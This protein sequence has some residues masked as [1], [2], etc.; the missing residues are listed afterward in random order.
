MT[1][2]ATAQI[3]FD[4]LSLEGA[5]LPPEWL[6]KVAALEAAAQTP[7]DYGIP[8]G[9]QLR[10]EIGRYWRIAQAVW[11][12]FASARDGNDPLGASQRLTRDLLTQ[13]FGF[14]DLAPVGDRVVSG[15]AFPA[16][17]EA[18]G[19]RAPVVFG[20]PTE[21]L[22]QNVP[23]HGDGTRRR[24]AWGVLQ[25]YLNAADGALWGLT[26]NG[27]SLRLGR[28]NASLTRPAWLEADLERIFTEERFADFSVLWLLVHASRFG[29]ADQ[30]VQEAPLERWREAGREQGSRAREVLRVGVE[31]ALRTLGQG[32]VAH[33][34]NGDLRAALASGGLTPGEYFNELLRL[35]YRVIFLLTV[36]ERGILHVPDADA[37]A[38]LLYRDGYGLRRLRER[39]VRHSAHD[40]HGDLWASLGP[41]FSGLG[42]PEGEPALGLPGLGGL[43]GVDQCPHLDAA[44]LENRALLTAVFRLS[45]LREGAALA[46]VNWKDMGV[47]EFGSVYESLLELVPSVSDGGRSF[48]L[49]GG[50]AGN[51]RKT[52][53]SYYTPDSLVQQ[54][55]DTALEPVVAQRLAEHSVVSD[56]ERALLSLAVVDPACGS[57]HF[58]LAAA[59][60]LA[61]HLARLRA[62][63]T[64]GAAEY[65]HALRDVVTHCIHGVDRNPMAL[66]L[67]RMALWLEAFTPDR[68]L[69]FLDHHLVCGDALLGLLDLGV[70]K[71]GIPDEAFKALTGDDKDVAKTLA[72]LNRAGRKELEK[73]NKSGQ[74]AFVLGTR[75]LGA[76][77]AALDALADAGL[78]GVAAKRSAWERLR[79]EAQTSPLALAADMFVGAF[80]MPK[81]LR[82]GEQAVTEQQA[83]ERWPTTATLAMV[84]E[85]TLPAT[86]PSANAGRIAAAGAHVL[87]WPL[88]FPQVFARGGFDVVLGNPPWEV[89]QLS[90]EEFFAARAPKVAKARNKAARAKE[91]AKLADAPAGSSERAVY[92]TYVA[93]KREAEAVNENYRANPRFVLTA[94]GKLNT[95]PLF[96]ETMYRAVAPTG[97]VGVVVPTGIATDDST[98]AFF[99]L[100]AE[101]GRLASLYDFENREALFADVHRSF[102]FSLMTLG[103]EPEAEFAF[104][105][106]QVTDLS[107]A[108]R[109]FR[110]APADFRLINPNTR[111]CPT[112]RSE[113]DA[114]MTKKIYR[115]LSV[116][117]DETRPEEE[118]NPWGLSFSQGLFN[119]ASDSDLFLDAPAPG[120]LPL[121]EA[122]MIHQFDHRWAT[123]EPGRKG[124]VAESRGLTEA[125]R[126]DPDFAVR[127]RYW[128]DGGAVTERLGARGWTRGWLMGW[129]DICRATDER[130]TIA[131]IMPRVAVGHTIPLFLSSHQD[132][133]KTACLMANLDSIVLDYV[134]RQKVGGT[135][136]TY[137]FLKQFPVLQPD[138]YDASRG[139]FVVPRVLELTYTSTNLALWARDLGYNGPPFRWDPDRR[140]LLRA[141][142][143][144]WFARAYGLTRDELHYVLDPTEVMGFDYP[145]ETFRVLKNNEEREF[146][147][148]RTRR[149]VL[150]AWDALAEGRPMPSSLSA[151]PRPAR[152]VDGIASIPPQTTPEVA[153]AL[154]ALA[155]VRASS[156]PLSLF[157]LARA[158]AVR[159]NPKSVIG[160]LPSDLAGDVAAWARVAGANTS[161]SQTLEELVGNLIDRQALT[162][163]LTTGAPRAVVATSY[164]PEW[165][166]LDPWYRQEAQLWLRVVRALSPD[167]RAQLDSL[168]TPKDR[169]YMEE[170]AA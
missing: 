151:P 20:P 158:F 136:L 32:F 126:S 64:P 132:A 167:T 53:G 5:I 62:G 14:T 61:G 147:E 115:R 157:D 114:E 22:D 65:R 95:Y 12:E 169:A 68:A 79:A 74:H 50:T 44:T 160:A 83:R 121:Y 148:Y 109:R 78:D 108:R 130:T 77:F 118:G 19:G 104:Y 41:V 137:G 154:V 159:L 110:L 38:I 119:M 164:T 66:E 133:H 57:G 81:R 101:G 166:A 11:G 48:T 49:A 17:F 143:D 150:E 102:K 84:L 43:F 138:S 71:D 31:E 129:R 107:D 72:K 55:L 90:E 155:M 111:T 63:G 26:T 42:R 40:T 56:A 98:K 75:D 145:S 15:R 59:R 47:E 35:V 13:V 24:S 87:H 89:S 168:A 10:D 34:A 3:Q 142:L 116:L 27:L 105:A 122:K 152:R 25:E 99:A 28:D 141:E 123:Y 16:A 1:R 45:W 100:V 163:H 144:A 39:S 139:E 73:R 113:F 162:W 140:A 156:K 58:L 127:P 165:E 134:A 52:T 70:M 37:N 21:S 124:E 33:P 36:E 51:E 103:R 153:R 112:F 54:L 86:H 106:A 29:R 135:H 18:L 120:A 67:A 93:A 91:I 85:G 46:R 9:L 97:R 94:V 146:G 23:R 60:R 170:R 4:A 149:L 161:A 2:R 6:G 128:V 7:A 92:D 117:I 125:E 80:L 76:A 8:K 88:A 131:S 82:D 96:A 30:S 69:G